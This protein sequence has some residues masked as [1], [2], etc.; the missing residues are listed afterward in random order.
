MGL[1][2]LFNNVS[3]Y[4]LRNGD[5]ENKEVVEVNLHPYLLIFSTDVN[6]DGEILYSEFIFY[7]TD[8]ESKKGYAYK[9][10]DA[11]DLLTIAKELNKSIS[12]DYHILDLY[13]LRHYNMGEEDKVVL[14]TIFIITLYIMLF[15]FIQNKTNKYLEEKEYIPKEIYQEYLYLVSLEIMNDELEKYDFEL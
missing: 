1:N 11:V 3:Y 9:N 15:Q 6:A 2:K 14:K 12:P 4:D 13:K 7:V 5:R 10:F 8:N